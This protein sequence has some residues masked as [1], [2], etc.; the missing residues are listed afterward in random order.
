M[1]EPAQL[2]S[3]IK[4]RV[5][6]SVSTV[7]NDIIQ[8]MDRIIKSRTTWSRPNR[9]KSISEGYDILRHKPKIGKSAD[10]SE[11][12]L[13]TVTEYE[14]HSL[15]DDS[16][17]EKRINRA[18]NKAAQKIKNKKRSTQHIPTPYSTYQSLRSNFNVPRNNLPVQ[19]PG[20]CY[21][22]DIPEHWRVDNQT[23]AFG[24]VMQRNKNDKICNKTVDNTDSVDKR[25][26]SNDMHSQFVNLDN[27]VK[28]SYK[29]ERFSGKYVT[30]YLQLLA[31]YKCEWLYS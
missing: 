17:D 19:C 4:Q 13:K 30:Q 25:P 5:Q 14:T 31:K 22:C 29:G 26:I 11:N 9:P 28:S 16:K 21:E 15:A 18:E 7:Q 23:G 8:H 1:S 12:G 27:T 24:E 10:Q 2:D 6:E 3:L 20:K